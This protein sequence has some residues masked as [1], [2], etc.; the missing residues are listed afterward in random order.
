MIVKPN[1]Q[2]LDPPTPR[3]AGISGYWKE[4]P[5][6]VDAS[7]IAENLRLTPIERVERLRKAL[8]FIEEANAA[9]GHR[10]SARR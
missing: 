3:R 4:S 1:E 5:P 8:E 6:G 2:G 10:L 7:L 9:R